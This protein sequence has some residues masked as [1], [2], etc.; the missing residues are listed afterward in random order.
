VNIKAAT[1]ADIDSKRQIILLTYPWSDFGRF[2][3]V[4]FNPQNT[5]MGIIT[6][7]LKADPFIHIGKDME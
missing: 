6:K 7:V 2:A 1:R 3:L 4:G 5:A